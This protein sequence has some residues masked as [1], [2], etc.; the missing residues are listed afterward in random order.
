MTA[1][2]TELIEMIRNDKKPGDALLIA[3][4]IILS[5]LMPDESYREPFADPQP[6]LI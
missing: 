3:A 2:E 4:G 6:E 5:Y 1:N